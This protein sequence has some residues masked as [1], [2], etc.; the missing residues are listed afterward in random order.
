MAEFRPGHGRVFA[1][2]GDSHRP[3]LGDDINA[4]ID[5]SSLLQDVRKQSVGEQTPQ[6]QQILQL[7]FGQL[8]FQ[9][10]FRQLIATDW[11]STRGF[12][13]STSGKTRQ[14]SLIPKSGRIVAHR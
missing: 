9:F 7:Q 11:S 6:N 5:G 4:V 12:F 10:F 14:N 2:E 1:S 8:Q 13:L 3:P